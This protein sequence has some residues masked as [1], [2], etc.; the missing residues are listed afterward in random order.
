M[1]LTLPRG[2]RD[3]EPEEFE[4][5]EEI[6]RRFAEVARL[7]N[8]KMM[9]PAPIEHL[10]TLRAKSGTDVD[11][12]IYAFRDKSDRE[13]GLRFDLTVGMTRYVCSRRDL[14]PPVK[15]ACVGGAWRYDEPQHARYRWFNQ[16]DLEIFGTPSV[17]ADAEV[18]DA[19]YKLFEALRLEGFS[20]QVG[21]RR[22]IQEFITKKLH[23]DSQ[24]KA[25][26]MMRVLDKVQKKSLD[27]L[28]SEYVEKGFPAEDVRA[29]FEFGALKGPPEKILSTLQEQK[30]ESTGELEALLDQL[31]HR[32]VRRVEY[33][34]S[35]VRGIDYYTGVVFEVYDSAHPDLGSLAGGGRFDL[36]PSAFG[37]PELSAT[38]AA[39]GIERE[40]ASLPD[41]TRTA[42]P[43]VYVVSAGEEAS[44]KA[45]SLLSSLR[46]SG[47]RAEA[48]LQKR[49]LG[50]QIE[51]AS[52]AGAAWVIIVGK[53]EMAA[54]TVTLR[55]MR[56]RRE[57]HLPFEEALLRVRDSA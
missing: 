13:I 57:Q 27:S 52:S 32:G 39:G 3:I 6:R 30:L 35:V 34:L 5:H 2:I 24:E 9:E 41:G 19:S 51:D 26:E 10:A 54:G 7:F 21:D 43:L 8:F 55:D 15:L 45:T 14:K 28:L 23:V 48:S 33:N 49:S 50:R 31:N 20:M 40:A 11:K 12:E 42:G 16:W 22:V 1:D 4:R 25:V 17:T 36:L 37:R 56:N 18:I 53:K 46:S 44:T 29:L 47:V 38:G